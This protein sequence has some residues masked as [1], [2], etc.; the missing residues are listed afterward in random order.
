MPTDALFSFEQFHLGLIALRPQVLQPVPSS[1]FELQHFMQRIETV[2]S[3]SIGLELALRMNENHVGVHNDFILATFSSSYG[4]LGSS[5]ASPIFQQLF[6]GFRVL[7]VSFDEQ[8]EAGC[9]HFQGQRTESSKLPFNGPSLGD[10]QR[11]TVLRMMDDVVDEFS[12]KTLHQWLKE[13]V[14]LQEFKLREQ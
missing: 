2:Q 1:N 7:F 9:I 11:K 5:D 6:D 3:D 13:P 14:Q 4:C 10:A 12:G 8:V